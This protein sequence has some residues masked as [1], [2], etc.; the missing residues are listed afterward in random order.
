MAEPVL[1]PKC[2]APLE[3]EQAG[4]LAPCPA[5]GV[6]VQFWIFP[7]WFQA[8]ASGRAAEN[9]ITEGES[10]CFYHPAKQAAVPCD[11]CG[12][13]LCALCDCEIQGKHF[14]PGCVSTRRNKGRLESLEPRRTMF[15]SLALVLAIVAVLTGPLALVCGPAAVF[16]AI[17]SW[18]M[19]SSII[20]RTKLRAILA[21]VLGLGATGF[22][23]W[24]LFTIFQKN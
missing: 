9:L 6:R 22:W 10:S 17:R 5:C 7:A 8:P 16:V 23:G 14:C 4:A 1:C 2:R 20:P 3:S 21:I 18:K 12:R 11:A 13:F 24:W 15:D 19:R